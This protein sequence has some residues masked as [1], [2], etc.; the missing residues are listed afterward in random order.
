MHCGRLLD[1]SSG[2]DV[3]GWMDARQCHTLLVGLR[4]VTHWRCHEMRIN[5]V[6]TDTVYWRVYGTIRAI[7][8]KPHG[9][10]K[11]PKTHLFISGLSREGTSQPK[12]CK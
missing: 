9:A 3:A 12:T 7:G 10:E 11:W 1:P 2:L 8:L 6:G 5:S 4:A